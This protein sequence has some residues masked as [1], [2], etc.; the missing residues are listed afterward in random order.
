MGLGKSHT[1]IWNYLQ[2]NLILLHVNNKGADQS[3]Q[4][5]M[6]I[7]TFAICALESETA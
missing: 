6:Q 2:E 7:I 4:P 3:G 5:H 1:F